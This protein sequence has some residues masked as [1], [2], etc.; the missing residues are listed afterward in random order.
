[1]LPIA[2]KLGVGG[3]FNQPMAIAVIGGLATSTLLSLVFVPAF[4][5]VVDD[6]RTTRQARLR[7]RA[8]ARGQGGGR[9]AAAGGGVGA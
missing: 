8:R 1:M 3:E 6:V 9:G 2:L 7:R 5:T 4:F